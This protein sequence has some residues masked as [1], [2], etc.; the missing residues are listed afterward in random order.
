MKRI[1]YVKQPDGSLVSMQIISTP[2]GD[3]RSL[4]FPNGTSGMIV[5]AG[6]GKG[7]SDVLTATSAHKIKIKLK[8]K[9]M[10]SF[11]VTFDGESRSIDEADEVSTS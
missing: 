9:L 8:A 3:V 1:R 10:A 4:I 6:S 11:G 7:L 5:D 2:V